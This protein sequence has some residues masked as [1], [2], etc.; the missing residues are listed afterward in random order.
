MKPFK[1]GEM[2]NSNNSLGDW[3][4]FTN[5]DLHEVTL[6]DTLDECCANLSFDDI[7]GLLNRAYHISL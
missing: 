4:V 5:G 7:A 1:T 6:F 3:D 2:C